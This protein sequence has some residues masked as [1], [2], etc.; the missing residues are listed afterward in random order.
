MY[1]NSDEFTI[2]LRGISWGLWFVF[3]FGFF[4]GYSNLWLPLVL[5]FSA[6]MVSATATHL[7]NE[8]KS[9]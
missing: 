1:P 7:E 2:L 6:V 5:F 8:S 4:V 9:E 3:V